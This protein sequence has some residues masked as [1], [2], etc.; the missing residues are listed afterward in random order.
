MKQ[1]MKIR[2]EEKQK[3]KKIKKNPRDGKKTEHLWEF[4]CPPPEKMTRY[5]SF[6]LRACYI[7]T[8]FDP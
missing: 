3:E 5:F 1:R 4:S 6:L 8:I 7:V 2:K